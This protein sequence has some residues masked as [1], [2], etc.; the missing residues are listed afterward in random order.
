MLIV[1]ASTHFAKRFFYR[2][3]LKFGI[4][5]Q[6]HAPSFSF[7]SLTHLNV[8]NHYHGILLVQI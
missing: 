2:Y 5:R 8:T 7:F 3:P 6:L 4:K 1:N